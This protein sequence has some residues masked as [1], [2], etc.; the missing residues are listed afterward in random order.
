MTCGLPASGKTTAAGRLHATLGGVLIRSCD[1]YRALG[2]SLPRWVEA[3][4]GFTVG[5]AGYER[6]RD[7]A[8]DEMARRLREALGGGAPRVILDAVHGEADKRAV[9]Y[10]TCRAHE[11][12]IVL[13]WCRCDDPAEVARRIRARHG[14]EAEPEHEAADLS[15]LRHLGGLWVDPTPEIP[16]P[17]PLTILV[18]DTCASRVV[19]RRGPASSDAE[20]IAVTLAGRGPRD[21]PA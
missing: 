6:V 15:V 10:A 9:V 21:V 7:L 12:S 4:R 1:V 11:A 18:Y 20:R 5:V 3:T 8:Y 16:G 2:I 17:S 13:V 19:D 14:R